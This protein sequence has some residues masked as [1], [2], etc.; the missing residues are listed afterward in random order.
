[1]ACLL[2]TQSQKRDFRGVI[3]VDLEVR[4]RDYRN[5]RN[6]VGNILRKN[7]QTVIVISSA[8]REAQSYQLR[9]DCHL[10]RSVA[11]S[12]KPKSLAD[13]TTGLQANRTKPV[14]AHEAMSPSDQSHRYLAW[15]TFELAALGNGCKT[16]QAIQQ[17]ISVPSQN[18]RSI[19]PVRGV[20]PCGPHFHRAPVGLCDK[21]RPDCRAER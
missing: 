13:Q 3:I 5:W 12:T 6:T 20:K 7:N 9:G 1:M 19:G 2:G 11:G 16:I 4:G 8:R 10:D 15:R 21:I 14:T 17:A 18:G